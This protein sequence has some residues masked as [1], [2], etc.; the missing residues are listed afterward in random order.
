MLAREIYR[1]YN[2]P[3]RTQRYDSCAIKLK[4]KKAKLYK[5][6]ICASALLYYFPAI[7]EMNIIFAQSVVIIN[8][9]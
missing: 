6:F 9:V 8:Y 2:I 7:P 1:C 4:E 3:S 5:K